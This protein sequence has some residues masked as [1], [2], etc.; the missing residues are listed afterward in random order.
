M[1]VTLNNGIEIP[2]IGMG[3]YPLQGVAMTKAVLSAVNCGYRAFDTA[4]AY[5][6]EVSLGNALQEVFRTTKIKRQN[7]FVT[8]KIGENL[9]HGMP[10]CRLFYAAYP[11]KKKDIKGIVSKQLTESLNNLQTEYLDLLLIHWPHPDFLVEIWKAME[12]EYLAG[13]VR[14][15]GVSNCREWHLKKILEASKIKPMVNQF[16]LH[17]LN[18]KKKLIA[19]CQQ[20]NIQVQAY[21]PLL[22]MN[23]KLMD[24][25]ILKLLSKKYNKSIPQIILR[26]D[27]QNGIIPI[28]KSGNPTRLLENI[29]I[30]DFELSEVDLKEVDKLNENYKALVESRYCPGY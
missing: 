10:D 5:G 19:F 28:P 16:E 20:L 4:H 13:R 23:P 18:T 30:F 14:A 7:V 22:V 15:I 29:S 21:S 9:E 8:S 2:K 3:T 11:N 26:W 6:N 24:S 1:N 17:P 12:E 25:S 27:L